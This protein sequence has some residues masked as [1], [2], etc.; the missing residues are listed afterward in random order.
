MVKEAFESLKK[1]IQTDS[2]YAWSWHCNVAMSF[3]D[4]V[5]NHEQAN[6][7]AARFMRTTFDV[8]VTTFAEWKSFTEEWY[9]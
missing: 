9:G 5:G 8:D 4:E 3:E 6:R 7:A 2:S 1:A